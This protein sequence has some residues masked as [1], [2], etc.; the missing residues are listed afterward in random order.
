MKH[1]PTNRADNDDEKR[2]ELL[3]RACISSCSIAVIKHMTQRNLKKTLVG[4]MVPEKEESIMVGRNGS[5]L[6][7]RCRSRKSRVHILIR[8]HEEQRENWEWSKTISSQS[9]PTV[10]WCHCSSQATLQIPSQTA[11]SAGYQCSNAWDYGG[12]SS[13]KSLQYCNTL[14]TYY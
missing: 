9:P 3:H 14:W 1:H 2:L 11:S 6:Q 4:L 12:N 7:R 10:K 5:K 8:K 13:F